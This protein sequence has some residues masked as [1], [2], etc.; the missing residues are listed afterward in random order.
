MEIFEDL[1]FGVQFHDLPGVALGAVYLDLSALLL[2]I[3]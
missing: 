3:C 2:R 1:S